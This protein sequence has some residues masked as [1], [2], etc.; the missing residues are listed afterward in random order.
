MLHVSDKKYITFDT[1]QF[2]PNFTVGT[3]S[4]FYVKNSDFWQTFVS[5]GKKVFGIQS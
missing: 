3:P 5:E 4:K 1:W 2:L